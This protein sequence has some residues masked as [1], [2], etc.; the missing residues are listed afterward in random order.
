MVGCCRKG[1]PGHATSADDKD[2]AEEHAPTRVAA[3]GIN[4]DNLFPCAE[5]KALHLTSILQP[6]DVLYMYTTSTPTIQLTLESR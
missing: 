6:R 5:P 2:T 4:S 1:G 3:G